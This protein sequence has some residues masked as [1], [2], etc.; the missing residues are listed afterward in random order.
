MQPPTSTYSKIRFIGYAIPT[1]PGNSKP[2]PPPATAGTYMGDLDNTT[3]ITARVQVMKNAVDTAKA[4]LP[5]D[6][7][8]EVINVFVAPEFFFGGRRGAYI[9]D[10]IFKT[11]GDPLITLQTQLAAAFPVADYPDW[12]FVCG[13]MPS[14]RVVE[15]EKVADEP[16]TN[17]RNNVVRG[18]T[19]QWDAAFGPMQQAIQVMLVGF[20]QNCRANPSLTVHCRSV[21]HSNIGLGLFDDE[22]IVQTLNTQKTFASY[23]D[24][25]LYDPSRTAEFMGPAVITEPMV[26]YPN[27]D[28]SNGDLK[29]AADDNYAIFRQFISPTGWFNM[30]VEVCLDHNNYRLRRNIVNNPFHPPKNADPTLR[31]A[32]AI[33]VH[34]IPAM[35]GF[36]IPP[37][38]AAGADGFVFNCD[39]QFAIGDPN[40]AGT[41]TVATTDT[42]NVNLN[43]LFVDYNYVDSQQ[44]TYQAHT[45]F[46]RVATPAHTGDPHDGN[47]TTVELTANDAADVSV[48]PVKPPA[49]VTLDHYF[50][51]GP[52]AIHIY[53]AT[54]PLEISSVPQLTPL[55]PPQG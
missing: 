14:A 15:W 9:W 54:T 48:V 39:G 6:P 13:T 19:E 35:G 1:N 18:L 22:Q 51:G 21:V 41:P 27:I 53:G 40:N 23:E 20:I 5:P 30:G 4:S 25:V 2:A 55:A 36:I 8:G 34:I 29:R 26:A 28:L 7:P 3:D 52:G 42:A 10:P 47:A 37:A 33:H 50:A 31:L 46:A 11:E 24:F 12:T 17:V 45:Q 32:S 38:I 49:A 43:C 44:T 16:L